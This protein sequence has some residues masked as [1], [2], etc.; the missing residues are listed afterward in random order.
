M[1]NED[2]RLQL[3]TFGDYASGGLR[4]V[5]GAM[6]QSAFALLA[7]ETSRYLYGNRYEPI[8]N[9][10]LNDAQPRTAEEQRAIDEWARPGALRDYEAAGVKKS[11]WEK[12]RQQ[13][14]EWLKKLPIPLP[15]YIETLLDPVGATKNAALTVVVLVVGLVLLALAAYSI[16]VP[17]NARGQIAG[18]LVT[19]GLG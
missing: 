13:S 9:A 6:P 5:S 4:Y 18:A 16:A 19:K 14:A 12:A 17:P 7:D 10:R 15:P 1:S 11:T 2:T 3:F 8:I